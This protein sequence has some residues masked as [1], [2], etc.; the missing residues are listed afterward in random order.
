MP[1]ERHHHDRPAAILA[2]ILGVVAILGTVFFLPTFYCD[3]PS[4][5]CDTAGPSGKAVDF[6]V[7]WA[8]VDAT[9]KAV[10]STGAAANGEVAVTG[11]QAGAKVTVTDC[12]DTAR[13]GLQQP[14]TITY[15]LSGGNLT[16]LSKT[17]TCADKDA[18]AGEIT[19]PAPDVV[20]VSADDVTAGKE[21]LANDPKV[22][23][24]TT[25]YTLK[26]TVTR[27]AGPAPSP[28]GL[29]TDATINVTLNLVGQAYEP[30]LT[31]HPKEATK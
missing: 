6:D 15:T 31:P 23:A 11:I 29:P 7:A 30:N 17:F 27:P 3:S 22:R 18:A 4:A 1:H 28:I 5:Q 9:N 13:A 26:V 2:S 20:K 25:T 12:T 14:A 19:F 16:P 10:A 8:K 24:G 21:S